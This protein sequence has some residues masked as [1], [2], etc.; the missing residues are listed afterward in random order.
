MT[1]LLLVLVAW[2]CIV[3]R[4]LAL[5]LPEQCE[6]K[7]ATLRRYFQTVFHKLALACS[8]LQAMP[9]EKAWESMSI[10]LH[11]TDHDA[12]TGIAQHKPMYITITQTTSLL[13]VLRASWMLAGNF[14]MHSNAN[15]MR[16]AENVA[17][18]GVISKEHSL[19]CSFKDYSYNR[20]QIGMKRLVLH[21]T[22]LQDSHGATR[23]FM[24]HKEEEEGRGALLQGPK[25]CLCSRTCG[26]ICHTGADM[27]ISMDEGNLHPDLLRDNSHDALG[28]LGCC[29]WAAGVQK[30]VAGLGVASPYGL[31]VASPCKFMLPCLQC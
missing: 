15:R 30:Q 16:M 1:F 28:N 21:A 19:T 8:Q 3:P 13:V 4:S 17:C 23:C 11:E 31:D 2:P 9:F 18:A 25:V 27:Y 29:N 5:Q 14:T 26:G 7:F 20:L 22:I 10:L 6:D 12:T 24:Q